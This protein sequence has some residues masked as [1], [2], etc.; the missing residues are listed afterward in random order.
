M[1]CAS[2]ILADGDSI[3]A[4]HGLTVAQGYPT[5]A[6][7]AFSPANFLSIAAVDGYT[8]QDI[9]N[10]LGT[11]TTTL[12]SWSS[13]NKVYTLMIGTNDINTGV[14]TATTYANIQSICSSVTATGAKMVALTVLPA[15]LANN[16]ET[17]RQALNTLIRNGGACSYIIA[18]VGND[19]TIGQAGQQTNTTY[20]QG[21]Q[22]HPT[23]AG[24]TIIAGYYRTAL[25]T[26]NVLR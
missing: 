20:Y 18:D 1:S 8:S 11:V 24:D 14:S 17:N 10:H 23:A 2:G 5:Q 3:T 12:N 7:T 21:D 25:G 26:L 4:N 13:P 22:V 6:L 19:A 16:F 15:T 9:I